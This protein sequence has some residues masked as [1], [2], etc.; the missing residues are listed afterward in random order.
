MSWPGDVVEEVAR[1]AGQYASYRAKSIHP[2]DVH[3][4]PEC[5]RCTDRDTAS[6]VLLLN[7]LADEARSVRALAAAG[8]HRFSQDA[9]EEMLAALGEQ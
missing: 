5:E 4:E 8:G 7:M 6:I 9:A 1:I 2:R 3:C